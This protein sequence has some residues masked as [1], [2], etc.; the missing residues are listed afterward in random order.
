MDPPQFI[1]NWFSPE[2]IR[3]TAH[4][5]LPITIIMQQDDASELYEY[6]LAIAESAALKHHFTLTLPPEVG[7]YPLRYF[8]GDSIIAEMEGAILATGLSQDMLMTGTASK[9]AHRA[10]HGFNRYL[11]TKECADRDRGKR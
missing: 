5:A 10:A 3:A 8:S 2:T 7:A 4:G 1:R 6:W 11:V 9:A